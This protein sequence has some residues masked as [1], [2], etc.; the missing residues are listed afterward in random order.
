M[1]KKTLYPLSNPQ[2]GMWYMEKIHPG[3]G[4]ANLVGSMRL[5]QDLNFEI[6]ARALD[7]VIQDND[8]LRLRFV[9][10]I[11]GTYQYFSDDEA[12]DIPFIDFSDKGGWPAFA[13]WVE[14]DAQIPL[15]GP[16]NPLYSMIIYKLGEGDGGV[17]CKAH[18]SM[19]DNWGMVFLSNQL[20]S[21]YRQMLEGV[22]RPQPYAH[23]YQDFILSQLQYESSAPCRK[24]RDYWMDKFAT[25]PEPTSLKPVQDG[26]ASCEA[27]RK[28]YHIS[29]QLTSSINGYCKALGVSGF[30]FFLSTLS[31]YLYKIT[32]KR[33]L[34]FGAPLINR[35]TMEE[36][37][38]VGMMI[39]MIP[40]RILIDPE[41]GLEDFTRNVAR[42]WKEMRSHQHPYQLLLNDIRT[43]HKLTHNLYEIMLNF[44]IAHLDP[45]ALFDIDIFFHGSMAESMRI[46]FNDWGNIGQ[47][48]VF[49]DYLVD[50]FSEKEIDAVFEH[51]CNLAEEALAD[52]SRPIDQL[53][54]LS[55][56][57]VNYLIH[58]LNRTETEYPRHKTIHQLFEEQ[59][60]RTPDNVALIFED[61]QLTFRELNE[62]ANQLARLLRHKGLRP[63]GIAGLLIDR[64]PELLIAILAVL[65]AGGA[66][67]PLDTNYPRDRIKLILEDSGAGL[68]LV[69]GPKAEDYPEQL[70][71]HL[72]DD[73]FTDLAPANLQNVNTPDHLAYILYTSGSTGKP[74]GV[75]IEHSSVVNFFTAMAQQVNIDSKTVLVLTSSSFD[76]F[77][78]ETLYPLI[79]GQTIVLTNEEEQLMP[80]SIA[81]L[82]TRH[83]IDVLQ[84]T[85]S[86]MQVMLT[87]GQFVSAL[88]SVSDLVLGGEP[89]PEALLQRLKNITPAKLFNG[90]G[91]TEATVYATFKE[92][93]HDTR[94]TIGKPVANTRVY[95]LNN[96]MQPVPA[97]VSGQLYI[98][99]DGLGRGYLNQP[100][101][102]EERFIPD[103]F[104]PGKRMYHTGDLAKWDD[105]GNLHFI[106]RVDTQIKIRGFRVELGEI[107]NVLQLHE[108]I[109]E[110]VV[111]DK[112]DADGHKFLS[113][114]LVPQGQPSTLEIRQYLAG[115]LPDYMIPAYYTFLESMPLNP[116]G[117]VCRNTLAQLQ[118]DEKAEPVAYA[119]PR[120]EVDEIL[121]EAWRQVISFQP[122]GIDHNFFDLGGDSLKIVKMLVG[123]MA[124]N[125]DLTAHDFYRHQTIRGL[126]D[127]IRGVAVEGEWETPPQ[128]A[129]TKVYK[130]HDTVT[131][132]T[133]ISPVYADQVLLT[134]ATGYLGVHLIKDLID[135]TEA[136]VY[137]LVR[138]INQ[139]DATKRLL[140]S[141]HFYFPGQL[142]HL[143]DTRIRVVAGDI[144]LES[145]GLSSPEYHD[146][147]QTVNSVI[148]TAAKVRHYGGYKEFERVNVQGTRHILDFCLR[149][150]QKKLHYV[151]T[152]SVSGKYLV[153]QDLG[154][155]VFTENDFFI[156]QHYFE[157]VYVRS[158]FEAE[159]LIFA[160]MSQGLNATVYRVGILSGRYSDGHF[161]ANIEDNALYNRLRSIINLESIPKQ[162]AQFEF[163]F[164]PV[165]CCSQALVLLSGRKETDGKV[166]HLFNHQL[167]PLTRFIS[168]AE[169]CGYLIAVL[170]GSEFET[171]I[172][173][174]LQDPLTLTGIINDIN[175]YNSIGLQSSP[176][177]SCEYTRAYLQQLGFDW[178]EIDADYLMK[179][180]GYM[181][182][183][184]FIAHRTE[185]L[186]YSWE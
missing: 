72:Q 120:N 118:W 63:E 127:K 122:I 136:T 40:V 115:C 129:V 128:P 44:Q 94:M 131:P 35:P 157:N 70:I 163:E 69:K 109:D 22:D 156:G 11:H 130:L 27:R 8:A 145:L 49:I 179:V 88:Q 51:L 87:D 56:D 39:E 139:A 107:E 151:S 20:N 26:Y 93:T 144:T 180:I 104:H 46:H 102:T 132:D 170:E 65:K 34:I 24:N 55:A 143:L 60:D 4:I 137:C 126:S 84:C 78:F 32:G 31:I 38:T 21:Y 133:S 33:D 43:H 101:L 90:Y 41:L 182:S 154:H 19:I 77:V 106:G 110:A 167:F 169:Q 6:L 83:H 92:V 155:A 142:D 29:Q 58:T 178:P 149:H 150:P 158:K 146:L 161:Q 13:R 54:F 100:Q 61:R 125:W 121:I 48:E 1:A 113:A 28:T 45:T 9:E 98:A 176:D 119:G 99:G 68:L 147:S 160:A 138:G 82:I 108:R 148:H 81:E 112:I 159:S 134:G 76:I 185:Q 168:A 80:S 71:V 36:K 174:H 62:S 186:P 103:P 166:F 117:K 152:T 85:P 177:I 141:L 50:L 96:Q 184:G 14:Q 140:K 73:A 183:I 91:P 153:R 66:Y 124:Y 47:F 162:F 16:E 74:K 25:L 171:E 75:M 57:H 42:E 23:R 7:L 12:P 64:S 17:L 53:N 79:S 135:Y 175:I 59:A 181:E 89:F 3:T 164:T 114:F 105:Q 18:H 116:N 86:R 52:T 123:L 2:Q 10:D 97:G 15:K 95:V 67:L 111:I 172:R 30:I 165:D 5:S 173:E 37:L